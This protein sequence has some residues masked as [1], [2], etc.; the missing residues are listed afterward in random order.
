VSVR[1]AAFFYFLNVGKFFKTISLCALALQ[2]LWQSFGYSVD[3]W[4]FGN[5][6]AIRLAL[7]K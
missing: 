7:V 1:V 3:L 5:V 2:A 6:L 4:G